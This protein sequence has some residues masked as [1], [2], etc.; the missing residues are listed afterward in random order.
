M[1][2]YATDSKPGTAVKEFKM[3]VKELHRHGIEVILDVVFNH[4][5]EGN[6]YGPVLCYKALA[7]Q[8]YYLKD[9]EKYSNYSGTGNTLNCNHPVVQDLICDCLRYFVTE[10]HVDGFRFDLASILTRGL[11]GNP[12]MDPPLIER[13]TMDPVLKDI[14]LIAEPWDAAGL[15]QLGG[16]PGSCAY[17]GKIG[18]ENIGIASVDLSEELHHQKENSRLA[19][20]DLMISINL[21]D[22]PTT[23]L[24]SSPAMMALA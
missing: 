22:N 1:N 19:F 12:L 4:T 5:S 21:T 10:L 2:R 7:D 18:M 3:M 17:Y 6:E 14:K 20:A 9:D 15:Y 8:V 23:A 16:L 13:I 11:S 24:T